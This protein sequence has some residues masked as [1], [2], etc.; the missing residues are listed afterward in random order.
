MS[1]LPPVLS[2]KRLLLRT[3]TSSRADA[4]EYR[5]RG[6]GYSDG[7]SCSSIQKRFK[8]I[9]NSNDGFECFVIL[10]ETST[11][12]GSVELCHLNWFRFK[13]S[14]EIG[15]HIRKNYR[16]N[17]YA[18]EA[19]RILIKYCFQKLKFRKIIADTDPDN[20][21]SQQVLKKLGF[22]LEGKIREKHLVRGKWIDEYA[23]GLLRRE[24]L[25][26]K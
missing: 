22:K 15:Y 6:T 21:A 20:C 18:T 2:G 23:Y 11:I 16:G 19:C 13:E 5:K 12:I 14:G 26:S 4:L 10:K 7:K 9:N 17:G 24:W 25:T 3:I 1:I 8:R